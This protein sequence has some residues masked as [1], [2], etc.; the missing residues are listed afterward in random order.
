M[1]VKTIIICGGAQAPALDKI[2]NYYNEGTIII[3]VDRGSLVLIEAGYHIDIAL[4]DFDS[5]NPQEFQTIKDN[6]DRVEVFSPMKDDT[7]MELALSLI[8]A[9]YGEPENLYIFGAIGE[10]KGRIDHF[11]AN[12]WM[13]Y[14][15]R[16]KN[17]IEVMVFIEKKHQI[18]FY[19]AGQH[20]LLPQENTN[21]LSII[22][23]TAVEDLKIQGALYELDYTSLSYPRAYISNEFISKDQAVHLNFASGLIMVMWLESID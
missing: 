4:G 23:L 6:T 20:I 22:S 9:E 12:L 3:G 5:V 17:L 18:R 21:Y 16:F 7:D 1:E 15:P 11:I 13:V 2:K 14:Q 19:Q 8:L 10:K